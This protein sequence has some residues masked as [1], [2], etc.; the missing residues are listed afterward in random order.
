LEITNADLAFRAVENLQRAE[1]EEFWTLAL[2][3]RKNLLKR[4]MMFRG[5]VD[6]CLVHPRDIFRFACNENASSILVAH[7]HPSGDAAPS[8]EDLRFTRQLVSASRLMEIPLV[9]HLIV[10]PRGFISLSREG[11]CGFGHESTQR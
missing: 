8:P 11:W 4:K 1:V 10:T 6:L 7:N 2:G 5:T 9:D 3:P